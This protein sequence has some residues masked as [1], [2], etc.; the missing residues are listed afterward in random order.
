MFSLS[1]VGHQ[2]DNL[3]SSISCFNQVYLAV[4]FEER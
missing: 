3:I 2:L 1:Y 4:L